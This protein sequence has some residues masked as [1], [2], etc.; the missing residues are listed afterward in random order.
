MKIL[1]TGGP[2]LGA[3]RL[4]NCL[5]MAMKWCVW[6]IFAIPKTVIERIKKITKEFC[7]L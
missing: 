2:S 4:L 3:I 5:M 7:I 1:V 6:I